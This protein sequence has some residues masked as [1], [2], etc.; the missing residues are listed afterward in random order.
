MMY[1]VLMR[2]HSVEQR[3]KNYI[4]FIYI[5]NNSEIHEW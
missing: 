1:N 3:Y 2:S 4:I 5:N